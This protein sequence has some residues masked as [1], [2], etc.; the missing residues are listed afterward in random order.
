MSSGACRALVAVVLTLAATIVMT[1]PVAAE[2][3]ELVESS[4]VTYTVRPNAGEVRARLIFVLNTGQREW[5]AQDWGPIVVE[6]AASRLR[7]A[8]AAALNQDTRS[9]VPGPGAPWK[10]ID[11]R[12]E[13]I[14]GR[15]ESKT[16]QITYNLDAAIGGEALDIPARV[17][18]SYVFVCVPGQDVDTHRVTVKVN[19]QNW[20]FSQ[21]GNPLEVNGS[22]LSGA[23]VANPAQAFTCIEGVREDRLKKAPLIGPA[24]REI[25]LQAW[26]TD[27]AW[28]AAAEER[29]NPALDAIWRFLGHDIPGEGKVII[30]EAPAPEAGGYA[31][32]HDT[33]GV[34]SLSETAG[35]REAE[36]Q[37]AHAWFGKDNVLE[38]W[39]REGLAEWIATSV[40]G[41][42]C[43]PTSGNDGEL[44]L[45]QWQ[46]L[47]P[48][49][50]GDYATV[51]E[52]QEAASCGIVSALAERMP[53]DL[54]KEEVL[55]SLLLGETKYIGSAGPE[56]GTS[57]VID[58]REWL[59]AVDERG[60]VPA[61]QA[62]PAYADNLADLDFAQNLLDEFGI[63]NDPLALQQ[64]SEA[65]AAYHQ[66]LANPDGF[67]APKAVREDMDNWEFQDAM[68]R[69]EQATRVYENL[70][71]AD[72]LIPEAE[73]MPIVQPQF[74]AAASL[75]ELDEVTTFTD[76]LLEGARE[77]VG[78]LGQLSDALPPGW[79]FPAA[80]N[81]A[82]AEQRFGDILPAITPAVSAAQDITDANQFL[83]QAGIL[84][85]YQVRF[86][87]TTTAAA[88][89]EL[90]RDARTDRFNASRAS[91]ALDLLQNEVG[92]WTIPEAVTQPL[93]QGQLEVG[94]RIVEDARA[95][96]VAARDADEALARAADLDL[97]D[98]G[99]R[100]EVQPRFESVTTGAE[101]AVLRQEIEGRRDAAVAVG[102][103]LRVLNDTVP[104][105]EIPVVVAE[106][107]A[108][109]DYAAAVKPAQAALE[110]VE[111]AA[112][113]NAS[114]REIDALERIREDF[115]NAE[116][117][118]TLTAGAEQ[119]ARWAQAAVRVR[120]AIDKAAEPRDML[121]SFGLWGVDVEPQIEE[122]KQAVI[123]ADIGVALTKAADVIKTID[124]AAG[125]GSLRLTGIVF[126]GVAV[127]GVAGLWIMLRRQA[128]PSWAR[129]TTPHWV[130]GGKKRRLL[131]RGK[132]KD[133]Q[134]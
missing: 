48:T 83:P 98:T 72:R 122:A 75:A 123:A 3:E 5:Q 19:G 32:A 50:P 55:G 101:M 62:D 125:A 63:P 120:L 59:D 95:V 112:E 89:D 100:E 70:V 27:E 6:N 28:L 49:A 106:P 71:E 115:E 4:I 10:E 113:A 124:G 58:Y 41:D 53:E 94:L 80:V 107:V 76:D 90:A 44:N 45:A 84:Q 36:H 21:S 34:V 33:P 65:R 130:E 108:S 66:F 82:L 85:K 99:L 35:T 96:V 132:K 86:E 17:D 110:W 69:I 31:S 67:R 47:V 13:S 56:I 16:F 39:L 77:V 1:L 109:G 14:P 8:G 40:Q 29:A 104:D 51:I 79:V 26:E 119:A 78:P 117:L 11:V 20:V 133:D 23:E 18:Q 42:A 7:A 88:L 121:E 37:M 97:V 111:N 126:F 129:S 60:L 2:S 93:E 68:D 116:D 52:E 105:W 22:E 81:T 9:D 92:D 127:I 131:G 61:A 128:G 25:E 103:A 24:D 74:E 15:R 102:N 12:T 43:A 73:L 46:L 57:T 91:F 30:R 118:E 54:F 134:R 38:L 114:L 64:R 87:N